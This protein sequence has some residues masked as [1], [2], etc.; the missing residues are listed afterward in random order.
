MLTFLAAADFQR[1]GISSYL[2]QEESES[3]QTQRSRDG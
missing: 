2:F 3:R 1:A